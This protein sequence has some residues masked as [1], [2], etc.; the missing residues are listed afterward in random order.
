MSL[1]LKEGHLE[2]FEAV[3]IVITDAIGACA[4]TGTLAQISVLSLVTEM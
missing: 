4:G 3:G 2:L 1:V